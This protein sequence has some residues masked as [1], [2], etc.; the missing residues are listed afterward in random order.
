MG[1]CFGKEKE[2]VALNYLSYSNKKLKNWVRKYGLMYHTFGM[3]IKIKKVQEGSQRFKKSQEG[4][5]M[6]K[7]AQ[8]SSRRFQM[9]PQG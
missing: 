8:E 5:R 6:L 2:K 9:D 1:G 3:G 4:S 7:D